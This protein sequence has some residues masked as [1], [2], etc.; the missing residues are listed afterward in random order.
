MSLL[1]RL[2]Q[3]HCGSWFCLCGRLNIEDT[4]KAIGADSLAF[5]PL[6]RLR[7]MLEHEA[8]TFCDACF[9]GAYPVPP[10]DLTKDKEEK[11]KPAHILEEGY[12]GKIEATAEESKAMAEEAAAMEAS[13]A[14]QNQK[15]VVVV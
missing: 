14:D 12:E 9:S 2:I 11:L 7:G 6:E 15:P 4:R 3:N 8:P 10:R 1:R 5:L 13:S